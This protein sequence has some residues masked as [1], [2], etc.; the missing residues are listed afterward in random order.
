[1]VRNR[2]I[3]LRLANRPTRIPPGA[4]TYPY[5]NGTRLPISSILPPE[6]KLSR[7]RYN[8]R[9]ARSTRPSLRN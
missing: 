8:P 5:L 4:K 1:M 7:G 2:M 3:H 9:H 6:P